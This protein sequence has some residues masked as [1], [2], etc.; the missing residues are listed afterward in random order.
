MRRSNSTPRTKTNGSL[1]NSKWVL[2]FEVLVLPIR[3]ERSIL[4][5]V[6]RFP[7]LLPSQPPYHLFNLYT[8]GWQKFILPHLANND[9]SWQCWVWKNSTE[10]RTNA[11]SSKA[12]DRKNKKL[13]H[14]LETVRTLDMANN[15][16]KTAMSW[17]WLTAEPAGC[18]GGA[19]IWPTL[20]ILCWKEEEKQKGSTQLR[21][22]P[23]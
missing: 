2:P 13:T 7:S 16:F 10:M 12:E 23:L 20:I 6:H 1:R 22:A 4:Y 15:I 3:L 11:L 5:R 18:K 17:L 14:I 19:K 9:L 21:L 8:Y